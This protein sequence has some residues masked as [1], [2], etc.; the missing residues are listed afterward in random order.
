MMI[1]MKKIFLLLTGI[2]VALAGDWP[3]LSFDSKNFMCDKWDTF[4]DQVLDDIGCGHNKTTERISKGCYPGNNLGTDYFGQ[5]TCLSPIYFDQGGARVVAQLM[6]NRIVA[7]VG[8]MLEPWNSG[9]PY[10]LIRSY[11]SI[12]NT[13]LDR[14]GCRE[15]YK[16][17]NATDYAIVNGQKTTNLVCNCGALTDSSKH[18]SRVMM[19]KFNSYNTA[20][21]PVFADP[22]YLSVPLSMCILLICGKLGAILAVYFKLP[23]IIGF[24]LAGLGIQNILSPMF[25]KGAGF[26]YPAPASELK[27]LALIVV[28]M[29]A[30]LAINFDEIYST[31]IPTFLLATIPYLGEFFMWTYAGK[32]Q[33][34]GWSTIDLGLWGSIMAPL[35]PTIVISGLLALLGNHK[36]DYGYPTKQIMISAPMESVLAIV[37]FGIFQNLEESERSTLYPWVEPLPLWLNSLLVPVNILFSIV[38]GVICGFVCS[39]YI[40]WRSKIKTDF[41]WVRVNKNPQMGSSTADLVFVLLVLCYTMYSLCT[42]QYIQQCSGVLVVFVMCITV[43]ILADQKITVELAQGLKGI[44][45]FAEVFLFT[46]T[47]TSLSF[48]SSNGPLYGQRGLSADDIKKVMGMMFIGFCGRIIA[49]AIVVVLL[50]N[51]MPVHRRNWEWMGGFWLVC[52]IYQLPKA[53]VQATLGSVAYSQHTIPGD[54]GLKKGLLIAQTTAFS[55]LIFAPL[56]AMLTNYVGAP[57]AE[58]LTTLDKKAG[59]KHSEFKYSHSSPHHVPLPGEENLEKSQSSYSLEGTTA[60]LSVGG[61][62]EGDLHEP[63]TIEDTAKAIVEILQRRSIH[64]HHAEHTDDHS[65]PDDDENK[66]QHSHEEGFFSRVRR[67]TLEALRRGSRTETNEH[68]HPPASQVELTEVKNDGS[69]HGSYAVV[70][71]SHPGDGTREFDGS[72]HP[73]EG[74]VIGVEDIEASPSPHSK[75]L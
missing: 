38:L 11:T 66:S 20:S 16:V 28:L 33:Y 59:W 46:L 22:I 61:E 18:V 53:S 72:G 48:D 40:D 39:R 35:S 7:D 5:C 21:T 65:H 71:T 75:Q 30:G 10:D 68:S 25:L 15:Q 32:T 45:L 73:P 55:I 12:C 31:S 2:A 26:P 54:E 19:D 47:G 56:G 41:L 13:L 63:E 9:P 50:Y 69:Y 44:W 43:S 34:S 1:I 27:T 4:C 52:C 70:S 67:N 37:F 6:S 64:G 51:V 60:K 8:W 49:L 62:D 42:L 74:F 3:H 29:R 58:H 14:L 36:K 17:I 23:P 57:I 24:I